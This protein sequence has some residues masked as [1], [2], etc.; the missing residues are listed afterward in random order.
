MN[1]ISGAA[2][3]GGTNSG[4]MSRSQVLK[5]L[6]ETGL[7]AVTHGEIEQA[8]TIFNY[9]LNV[10]PGAFITDL[11]FAFIALKKKQFATATTL[12][13]RHSQSEQDGDFAHAFLALV[14]YLNNEMAQGLAYSRQAQES[15]NPAAAQLARELA[16]EIESAGENQYDY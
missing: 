6:A 2:L 8:Q 13:Q 5:S 12:L 16:A 14:C 15:N 7:L 11:G 1:N 9:L 4:E 10:R 3:T